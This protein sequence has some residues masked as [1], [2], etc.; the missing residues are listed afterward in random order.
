MSNYNNKN[1]THIIMNRTLTIRVISMAKNHQCKMINLKILVKGLHLI[2]LFT[3]WKRC[4]YPERR[5][6]INQLIF[7]S[8]IHSF[9]NF[10]SLLY[11]LLIFIDNKLHR[12]NDISTEHNWNSCYTS[13]VTNDYCVTQQ[14]SYYQPDPYGERQQYFH[15]ITA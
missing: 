2:K 15:D 10:H 1:D 14:I 9:S 4:C 3:N 11:L 5:S 7:I 6:V 8:C 12:S 13:S